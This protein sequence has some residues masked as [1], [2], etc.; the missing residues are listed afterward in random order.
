MPVKF[1]RIWAFNAVPG[2]VIRAFHERDNGISFTA[3][4][5]SE[6]H[7]TLNHNRLSPTAKIRVQNLPVTAGMHDR[8]VGFRLSPGHNPVE[9]DFR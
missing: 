2:V 6:A 7:I 8:Q 1:G 3:A 5:G 4:S 9:I